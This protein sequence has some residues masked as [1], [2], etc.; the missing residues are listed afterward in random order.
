MPWACHKMEA[1][2]RKWRPGGKGEQQGPGREPSGPGGQVFNPS[3]VPLSMAPQDPSPTQR[4]NPHQPI[5]QAQEGGPTPKSH[6]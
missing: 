2:G 5:H 4:N 6:V 1:K 3:S